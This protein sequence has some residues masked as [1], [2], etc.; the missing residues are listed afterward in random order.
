[1]EQVEQL[2][3]TEE[4]Q[5]Q[6]HTFRI[7][8]LKSHLFDPEHTSIINTVRLRNSVLQEILRLMSLSR[9]KGRKARRGRISY[10]QLGINQLGAVYE[11]LLSYSGFLAKTDLYEVKKA[12]EKFDELQQ[13]YFVKAGDLPK[14]IDEEKVYNP[15]GSLKK[16]AKGTFIYRLAGRNREKSA[17]YYTPE[18]LTKCLVKYVLKELLKDKTA[19]EIL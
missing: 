1:D 2:A 18:V 9:P 16:Y 11:A 12:G 6:H 14:Y 5:P 8:P 3:L 13:A 15:D 10:A 4:G 17:S 7:P 19:D